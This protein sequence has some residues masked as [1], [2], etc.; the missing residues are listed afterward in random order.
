MRDQQEKASGRARNTDGRRKF[1]A[2]MSDL[3]IVFFFASEAVLQNRSLF[4]SLLGPR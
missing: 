3:S 1:M 4:A 2:V